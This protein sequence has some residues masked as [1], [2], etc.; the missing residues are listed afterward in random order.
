MTFVLLFGYIIMG[1]CFFGFKEEMFSTLGQAA[2]TLFLMIMG[3]V[4]FA[5]MDEAN[6]EM[7]YI[8]FFPFM[9]LFFLILLNMFLAIVMST[10]DQLRKTKQIN[11]EAMAAILA[12]ETK[13]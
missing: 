3:E 9:I 6:P 12:D 1:Y 2:M 13:K 8:F 7:S 10:Y 5:E 4:N 11:T